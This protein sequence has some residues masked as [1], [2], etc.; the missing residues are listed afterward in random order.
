VVI[1]KP[2]G[3]TGAECEEVLIAEK[4]TGKH[5]FVVKQNRYSPPSVWLKDMVQSRTWEIS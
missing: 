5:V 3:I 4:E 2:M 1:E